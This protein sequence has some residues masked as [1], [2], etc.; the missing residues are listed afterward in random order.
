MGQQ[1]D[2]AAACS[3]TAGTALRFVETSHM[4]LPAL[5]LLRSQ[6]HLTEG[7]PEARSGNR[8]EPQMHSAERRR[9][10]RKLHAGESIQTRSGRGKATGPPRGSVGAGQASTREL[11]GEMARFPPGCSGGYT[12]LGLSALKTVP[13]GRVHVTVCELYLNKPDFKKSKSRR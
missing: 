3:P 8:G 13:L 5:M 7:E 6:P 10:D 9:P 4:A 1:N 2:E 12:L 11:F